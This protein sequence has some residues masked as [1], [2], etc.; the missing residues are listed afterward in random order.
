MLDGETKSL[1]IIVEHLDE[2]IF[3]EQQLKAG[4]VDNQILMEIKR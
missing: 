3:R 4:Q 2:R 1:K